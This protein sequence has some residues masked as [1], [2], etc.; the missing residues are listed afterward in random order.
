MLPTSQVSQDLKSGKMEY[1]RYNTTGL[2]GQMYEAD[3]L[4]KDIRP[5]LEKLYLQELGRTI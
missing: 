3:K 5:Y 2:V 4:G 1:S